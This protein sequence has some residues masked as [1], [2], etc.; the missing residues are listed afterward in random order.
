M[1]ADRIDPSPQKESKMGYFTRMVSA[2]GL[3]AFGT[4]ALGRNVI[5]EQSGY[6][7]E[8]VH[9]SVVQDYVGNDVGVLIRKNSVWAQIWKFEAYDSQTG[10]PGDIN[11]IRIQP[12]G[13][14]GA[15]RLRIVGAP[16]HQ[17]GARD[18]KQIDLLT[19]ADN[20]TELFS[21]N[22]SGDCGE[23]GASVRVDGIEYTGNTSDQ[24]I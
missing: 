7:Q 20:T 18:V 12:T 24:H 8:G 13:T 16:G 21:I 10:Q 23:D 9:Y 15:I 11:Y 17:Y 22:I 19:N 3:I 1:G 14:V 4:A 6:Y 2:V 5:N